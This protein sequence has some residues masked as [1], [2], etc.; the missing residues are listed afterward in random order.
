M[1]IKVSKEEFSGYYYQKNAKMVWKCKFYLLE[2]DLTKMVVGFGWDGS[3]INLKKE[4]E[5]VLCML[6]K[7]GSFWRK[8]T[9]VHIFWI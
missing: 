9:Y 1:T 5:M 2:C 3:K 4:K 7:K 8:G 6:S